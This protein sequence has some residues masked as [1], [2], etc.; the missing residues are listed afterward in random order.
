MASRS[1]NSTQTKQLNK[2]WG[3]LHAYYN[4]Q[5][6]RIINIINTLV[7]ACSLLFHWIEKQRNPSNWSLQVLHFIL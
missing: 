1:E 7:R 4:Y 6:V 3:I 5:E 2:V